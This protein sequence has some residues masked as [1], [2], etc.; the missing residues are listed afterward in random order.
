MRAPFLQFF[1]STE[2][3]ANCNRVGK[4]SHWGK[5]RECCLYYESALSFSR[6]V[7]HVNVLILINLAIFY[8][9]STNQLDNVN[10]LRVQRVQVNV[11]FSFYFLLKILSCI[12]EHVNKTV[13][14]VNLAIPPK[15]IWCLSLHRQ[16]HLI[17]YNNLGSL[18]SILFHQ[19]MSN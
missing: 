9:N 1:P 19:Q 12:M 7:I 5:I 13:Q 10:Y 2:S 16:F 4:L 3:H 17:I 11:F 6:K 8:V 15:N 18:K 14:K